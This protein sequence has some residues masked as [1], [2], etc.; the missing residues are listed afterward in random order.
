MDLKQI[1]QSQLSISK[2]KNN[3]NKSIKYKNFSE[4]VEN[5]W[6][7]SLKKKKKK[8]CHIIQTYRKSTIEETVQ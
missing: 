2:S 8:N 4:K 3:N 1:V 6:I 5:Q 7:K